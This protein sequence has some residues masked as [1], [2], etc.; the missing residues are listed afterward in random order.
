[1]KTMK[2]VVS[3]ALVAAM[4]LSV[5]ACGKNYKVVDKKTF[6][7]ALEDVA[8]FDEDDIYDFKDY[9]DGAEHD[10]DCSDGRI[11]YEY[12]QFEDNEAAMDYFEDYWYDDYEDMVDDGDFSGRRSSVITNT[13]AYIL[14]NGESDS[15]DFFDD[16]IYGGFF[17][18]EDTVVLVYTVSDRDRDIEAVNEF[19]SAIGYP[20]P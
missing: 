8:G 4:M 10:L 18:K 15:D 5:A 20:H 11:R 9:Y 13:S 16:D 6:K 1:M 2:K 19:L 7:S 14:V 12:I 17:C 3:I